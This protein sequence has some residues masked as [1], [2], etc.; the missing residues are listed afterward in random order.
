[1]NE[2]QLHRLEPGQHVWHKTNHHELIVTEVE[3]DGDLWAWDI[4][5]NVATVVNQ[6]YVEAVP[7]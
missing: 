3:P 5:A 7:S 1:M 4:D 2:V 6:Y